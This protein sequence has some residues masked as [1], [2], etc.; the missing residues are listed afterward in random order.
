M[1]VKSQAQQRFFG[2]VAG[3]NARDAHGLSQAQARE[4]LRATPKRI[5]LPPRAAKKKHK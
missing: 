3:G 4:G 2:A 5:Y 1:P